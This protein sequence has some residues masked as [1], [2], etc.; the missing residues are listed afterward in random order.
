MAIIFFC[1]GGQGKFFEKANALQ[2]INEVVAF[3]WSVAMVLQLL[4]IPMQWPMLHCA[5]LDALVYLENQSIYQVSLSASFNPLHS[6]TNQLKQHLCN[7]SNQYEKQGRFPLQK[8]SH[9]AVPP[10]Q[11]CS[12]SAKMKR[13]Q[14]KIPVSS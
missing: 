9:G 13:T 14:R 11:H 12:L 3:R 6:S 8:P 4:P 10:N 7:Q 1:I 5:K 2:Y